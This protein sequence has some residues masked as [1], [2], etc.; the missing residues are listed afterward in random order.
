MIF[1]LATDRVFFDK[2]NI[3]NKPGKEARAKQ[4]AYNEASRQRLS[5]TEAKVVR[6]VTIE[7]DAASNAKSVTSP[8]TKSTKGDRGVHHYI[9]H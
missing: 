3:S 5:A 6:E 4:K 1:Y 7:H 9:T 2:R 8:T